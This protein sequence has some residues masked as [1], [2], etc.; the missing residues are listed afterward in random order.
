MKN[1]AIAIYIKK[2]N[3]LEFTN[4]SKIISVKTN[5][6]IVRGNRAKIYSVDDAGDFKVV[7]L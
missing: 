7:I 5:S 3:T 2:L 1:K 6:Q 4:G